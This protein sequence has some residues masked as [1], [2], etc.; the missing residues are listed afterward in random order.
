[1][2]RIGLIACSASKLTDIAPAAEL[3]TGDLFTKSREYVEATCDAYL[4]LSAM[5]GVVTP[6]GL[7]APYEV[8][9]P[10]QPKVARDSWNARVV[11]QLETLLDPEDT[12]VCLAGTVYRAWI[13]RSPWLVEVP[14]AGLGIGQQKAWLRT[15]NQSIAEALAA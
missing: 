4:I 11:D 6:G 1:M 10:A 14:L 3:Y 7:L 12:I 15:R 8:Y 2:A 5:W 9:L 13:R